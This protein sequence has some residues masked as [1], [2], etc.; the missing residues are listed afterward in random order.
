MSEPTIAPVGSR[1]V[2]SWTADA[3]STMENHFQVRDGGV[4]RVEIA[5]GRAPRK[6]NKIKGQ[7]V[8]VPLRGK[9]TAFLTIEKDGEPNGFRDKK[10]EATHTERMVADGSYLHEYSFIFVASAVGEYVFTVKY[11]FDPAEGKTALTPPP[12]LVKKVKVTPSEKLDH[13]REDMMALIEKWFPS[14]VID[15]PNI[16]PG[17]KMDILARAGWSTTSTNTWSFPSHFPVVPNEKK[18]TMAG[19]EKW[20]QEGETI[21]ANGQGQLSAAKK[22]FN[23]QLLPARQ[24]A[25]DA[26]GAEEKKSK[27]RP[28]GVAIVTSCIDVK[29]AVLAMWADGFQ[30]DM[31]TMTKP[32]RSYYVVATEEYAKPNPTPPKPGDI[33][34]LV[35]ETSRHTFQHAC[36]MVSASSEIWTTADG[37][38]GA[39]PEQTATISNKPLS[40]SAGKP[41]VPMFFSVTDNKVKAVH[42]WV[43]IDKVKN[44][45]YN[46]DGSR[47]GPPITSGSAKP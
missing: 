22:A 44:G 31:N 32:D 40:W 15:K 42:G 24:A 26:L 2:L 10:L 29:R 38:G 33:L 5:P 12:T 17:E 4:E 46:D 16:P 41:S 19:N 9:M 23:T 7:F 45:K 3:Y 27:P 47:K 18:L 43:D 1:F 35:L 20:A 30:I 37:G 34:F 28:A 21:T 13:R 6:G 39:T 8:P 11:S 14:A 25:Y 36:I